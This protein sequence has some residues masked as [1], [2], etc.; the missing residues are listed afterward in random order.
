MPEPGFKRAPDWVHKMDAI[1]I[2]RYAIPIVFG[3]RPHPKET[4]DIN[5][6]TA[7][8]VDLGETPFLLTAAHVL[9]AALARLREPH[10]HLVLGPVEVRLDP[11]AVW[12]D[13]ERDVAT[14]RLTPKQ[15]DVLEADGL[16][17]IRPPVW[18]PPPLAPG[19]AVVMCG[20][21]GPWR[22]QLAWDELD[23]R[24]FVM[25]ALVHEVRDDVFLCQLEPAD[26]VETRAVTSEEIPEV[27]LPGLSGGPAFVVSNNPTE[28]VVPQLCGVATQGLDLGEGNLIVRY[29]RLDRLN[30][31]GQVV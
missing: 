13:L 17:I 6:A 12:F 31:S 15:R 9:D 19:T 5:A 26:V 8:V 27:A 11:N 14:A 24:S 25:L 28:L 21:P 20:Y 4:A 16:Y 18:P 23:F 7:S 30:R 10:S 1:L 2:A 22:L 3:Q 29:A